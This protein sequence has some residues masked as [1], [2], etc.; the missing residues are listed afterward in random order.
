MEK[1]VFETL[2]QLNCNKFVEKKNDLSYI[3]WANAWML[4]KEQFPDA[5]YKVCHYDGKP[6]L[7]DA[8]L[9]YM[10]STEVTIAGETIGM[11]LPVLDY[12]NKALPVGKATMFDIN[13]AIM[14]CLTKNLAMFGLGLYIY[15]GEDLPGTDVMSMITSA[16]TREELNALYKQF[17]KY[18]EEII[19][20]GKI[21]GL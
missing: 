17:P 10:V 8:N 20:Q 5:N 14:R 12:R 21:L 2:S 15:A 19:N 9:G 13:T 4:C 7:E 1:K 11:S 16:T 3:S 18:K 6:W